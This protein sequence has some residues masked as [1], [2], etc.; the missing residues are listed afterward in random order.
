MSDEKI[1][2]RSFLKKSTVLTV[3]TA[4][5]GIIAASCEEKKSFPQGKLNIAVIGL[6]VGR[7]N[8]K[9]CIEAGENIVALC[10]VDESRLEKNIELFKQ[11]N[12]NTV[13]PYLFTDYRIMFK[14]IAQIIDAVIVATPDHT[15][16]NI[17]LDAMKLGKHVY[18]QKPLTHNVFEARILTQAAQKYKN[19]VTQMGNQ[20]S[21]REGTQLVCEAIW[22]GDFGEITKVEAWTNRPIWPQCLNKPEQEMAKPAGLNWES[23]L[24]PAT[25][26]PYNSAY[27]PFNWRGW[28][29]FGTGALGDMACHILD[30][31]VRALQ[32]KY[33]S[34]IQASS[35]RWNIESGPETEKI[36]FHFPE[37][38]SMPKVN[39]P[40]VTVTWYDGG[41]M[42]DR[43]MYLEARKLI[44]NSGGGVIFYGTK[45][46]IITGCYSDDTIFLPAEKYKDYVPEKSIRRVE[47]S[48]EADWIRACKEEPTKRTQPK[49]SFDIAGPLTEMIT[50]GTVAP[51]LASLNRIIEWDGENMRFANIEENERMKVPLKYSIDASGVYPRYVAETE[52]VNALEFAQSLV[53]RTPRQGWE[54]IL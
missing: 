41:M 54:L 34:H 44:G 51:R 21:S 16:A 35:S 29:E 5:S 45:G 42:P 49:S 28:W 36:T 46:T 17:T 8:M 25:Y 38:A 14:K 26:R 4:F 27:H 37:R 39:M 20:G 6:G 43:P 33:P 22:S 19:V 13:V 32:L 9:A 50:M 47:T 2:R 10:D 11:E 1:A 30:V 12:P 24:G 7:S 18:T 15:H 40:R 31:A 52:I 3:S 53:K 48:H 23:W